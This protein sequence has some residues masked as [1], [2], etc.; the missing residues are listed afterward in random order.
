MQIIKYANFD[1]IVI[2][3]IYG[4]FGANQK[5][6]CRFINGNLLCYNNETRTNK[7]LTQLSYYCFE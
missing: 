4:K 1:V 2:F 6:D 3:L 5:P 7:P